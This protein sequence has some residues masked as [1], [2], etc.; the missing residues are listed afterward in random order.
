MKFYHIKDDF[1]AHLQKFDTKVAENKKQTRPY[2]GVVLEIN[3]V[4]Y[5][6]PFSSLNRSIK[7]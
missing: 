4:K 1:I 2:V 6:A 3:S 5:Y 7:K